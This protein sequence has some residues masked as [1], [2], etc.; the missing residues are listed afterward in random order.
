MVAKVFECA[1]T[2]HFCYTILYGFQGVA[3]QWSGQ[4]VLS[5]FSVL[6]KYVVTK[7]FWI[8]TKVLLCS[9]QGVLSVVVFLCCYSIFC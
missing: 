1:A 6:L 2:V 8:V 4:G 7:T 3:M 9:Y 5:G